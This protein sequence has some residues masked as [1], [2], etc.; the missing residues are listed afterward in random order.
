M[1]QDS[2]RILFL[3]TACTVRILA[4][5]TS[6]RPIRVKAAQ[7][8][9]SVAN[10]LYERMPYRSLAF[11]QERIQTGLITRNGVTLSA[12]DILKAGDV[13][14]HIILAQV[15]PSAPDIIPVL[16]EDEALIVVNKPAPLPIHAG[17]R[18]NRNSLVAI[19][20][21]RLNQKLY[22]VHRLDAVTE[23]IV[24]LAKTAQISADWANAFQNKAIS[25]RYMALCRFINGCP[26]EGSTW[27]CDLPIGRYKSFVFCCNEEA[28]NPKKALTTFT[29]SQKIDAYFGLVA[30]YPVSGRTHQIR[31]HCEA[32]KHPIVADTIYDG[33]LLEEKVL[34]FQNWAIAL[35]NQF[36]KNEQTGSEF[37]LSTPAHWLQAKE[38]S[39]LYEAHLKA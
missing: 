7:N 24:V 20:E 31:L 37:S 11:W 32:M 10:F 27:Q 15:E 23:G 2:S 35:Q 9:F 38:F 13:L 16:F 19:L 30:C 22:V 8:G 36:I 26:D 14:V 5:Y 29:L 25:K 3:D 34:K 17:G 28:Q 12:N 33:S 18:Y 4:P 1:L 6:N 39:S 21:E